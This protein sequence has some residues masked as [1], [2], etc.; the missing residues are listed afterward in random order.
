M[1]MIGHDNKFIQYNVWKTFGDFIP[2][3]F[4]NFTCFGQ[5]DGGIHYFTKKIFVVLGTNGDK[6]RFIPSVI[7]MQTSCLNT[8]PTVEFVHE[9]NVKI[10]L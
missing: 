2:I 1:Q 8:V 10:F 5:I 7:P 6:I 4:C 9:C 3:L